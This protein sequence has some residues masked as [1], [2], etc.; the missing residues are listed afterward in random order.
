[1][2]ALFGGGSKGFLALLKTQN[3]LRQDHGDRANWTCLRGS[4]KRLLAGGKFSIAY[5][6]FYI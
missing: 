1:M 2:N 5:Q 3:A 6:H 4:S